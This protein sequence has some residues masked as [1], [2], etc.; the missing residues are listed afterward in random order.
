MAALA[1]IT[2]ST[3]GTI[4]NARISGVDR[5]DLTGTPGVDTVEPMVAEGW[6]VD[7]VVAINN[8]GSTIATSALLTR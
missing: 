6:N 5:P 2:L 7:A 8:D 1:R 4:L 3:D